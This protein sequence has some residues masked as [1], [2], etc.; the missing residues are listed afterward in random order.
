MLHA[1]IGD[2]QTITIDFGKPKPGEVYRVTL[3]IELP[4]GTIEARHLRYK[5][6]AALEAKP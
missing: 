5:F 4:D 6:R 2:T 3:Q 1:I